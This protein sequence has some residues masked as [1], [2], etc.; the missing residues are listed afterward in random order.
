[1]LRVVQGAQAP[2]ATPPA[3]KA[4]VAPIG[5][6]LARTELS[7]LAVAPFEPGRGTLLDAHD[8]ASTGE[9]G[10][11]AYTGSGRNV[12]EIAKTARAVA[13]IPP[14][15][16]A[17]EQRDVVPIGS[18]LARRKLSGLTGTLV[19]PGR[20]TLQTAVNEASE[21]AVLELNG[22]YTGSGDSVLVIAQS[23]TLRAVGMAVI[24]GERA[25]RGVLISGGT[26]EI[27]G[28]TITRGRVSAR[29]S[30]PFR[31]L[32]PSPHAPSLTFPIAYLDRA[33]SLFCRAGVLPCTAAT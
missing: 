31:E 26:V 16:H 14:S 7:G 25:R 13:A 33:R 17:V 2:A 22:T 23:V 5:L 6:R 29:A 21:G 32:V 24:D 9:L 20:G 4:D 15:P 1:M 28:L 12:L 11:G 27:E 3:P 8:A 30:C 10:D 19:D 18:R